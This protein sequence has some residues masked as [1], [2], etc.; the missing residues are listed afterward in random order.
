M[1]FFSIWFFIH[2]HSQFTGQQGKGK[3]ISLM[4]DNVMVG[5]LFN[6]RLCGDILETSIIDKK[7]Q[8]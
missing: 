5:Y 1:K 2:E 7:L 6:D 3:T 8:M 4:I